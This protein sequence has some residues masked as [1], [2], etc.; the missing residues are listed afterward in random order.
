MVASEGA[1]LVAFLSF[2][3]LSVPWRMATFLYKNIRLATNALSIAMLLV[4]I[5]CIIFVEMFAGLGQ[6]EKTLE[7]YFPTY[8][9]VYYLGLFSFMNSMITSTV[10]NSKSKFTMKLFLCYGAVFLL[11]LLVSLAYLWRS[12]LVSFHSLFNKM[13]LKNQ[14]LMNN[15]VNMASG[16]ISDP[17]NEYGAFFEAD[18]LAVQGCKITKALYIASVVVFSLT[19]CLVLLGNRCQISKPR[20][21]VVAQTVRSAVGF[22]PISLRKQTQKLQVL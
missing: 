16:E 12:Y 5:C 13:M 7:M 19:V 6:I 3:R 8:T 18:K 15:I 17:N 2:K 4:T 1:P 22:S 20:P 21:E 10:I 11:V 9:L 14:Q